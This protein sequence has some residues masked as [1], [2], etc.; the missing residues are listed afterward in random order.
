M[1]K[2]KSWRKCWNCHLPTKW[3][4]VDFETALHRGFCRRRKWAQYGKALFKVTTDSW[5][6]L[7]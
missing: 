4:D 6:E 5:E 2:I 1:I 3:M 7:K